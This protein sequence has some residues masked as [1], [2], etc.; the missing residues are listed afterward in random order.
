[1][2]KLNNIKENIAINIAG[3][4]VVVEKNITYLKLV[5]DPIFPFFLSLNILNVSRI[6]ITKNKINKIKSAISKICRLKSLGLIKLLLI[7]VKKVS[8]PSKIQTNA[9][10]ITHFPFLM[11]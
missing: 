1:M 4:K 11:I 5:S 9:D 6:M 8:V 7:K 10:A 3:N 2:V